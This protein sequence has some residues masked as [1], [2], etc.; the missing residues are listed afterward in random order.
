M[1]LDDMKNKI[2]MALQNSIEQLA[3]EIICKQLDEKDKQIADLE[4]KY[5]EEVNTR[6]EWLLNQQRLTKENIALE[7]LLHEKDKQIKE[8]KI[9]ISSLVY[10]INRL[11]DINEINEDLR[12]HVE[13]IK[14]EIK[15]ADK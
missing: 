10:E 1:A 15:E 2:S 12:K 3:F 11:W 14:R 7:N 9:L 8:L 6:K 13:K 4:E 5:K